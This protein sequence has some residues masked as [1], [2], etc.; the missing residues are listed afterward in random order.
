MKVLAI[1]GSPRKNG[2]TQVMIEE[3]A[4]PLTRADIHF[5]SVSIADY[6]IRPCNACEVCYEKSWFCP[7]DDDAIGLLKKMNDADGLIVASPVYG[8]G[9]TA[10]LKALLDRSII[11]YINQDFKNKVGGAIVV[12]GGFHGGQEFAILQIISEFNF[13]GMIVANPRMELFGAM[14]TANARGEIRED[15]NGLQSAMELGK[16]MV[17]LLKR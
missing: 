2:N 5:E 11:P 12:G 3:A 9:V 16:R 14:G 8:A 13:H 10:Q 7:I 6:D 15:E 1:N 17:E 4:K